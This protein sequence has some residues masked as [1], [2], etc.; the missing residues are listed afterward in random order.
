MARREAGQEAVASA[1]LRTSAPL[2]FH[3]THQAVIHQNTAAEHFL[4]GLHVVT[5]SGEKRLR[6]QGGMYADDSPGGACRLQRITKRSPYAAALVI[7]VH[8]EA[9]QILPLDFHISK[10]DHH[11]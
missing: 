11:P 2:H 8:I 4:P 1:P 10:A 6:R 7:A 9:V 3:L 5:T